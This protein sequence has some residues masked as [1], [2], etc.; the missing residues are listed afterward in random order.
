MKNLSYLLLFLFIFTAC[1][2][3]QVEEY[4]ISLSEDKIIADYAGITQT[5][6]VQSNDDNW[7]ILSSSIPEWCNIEKEK[8]S[9]YNVEITISPNHTFHSREALITFIYED[10]SC[11]LHIFQDGIQNKPSLDWHTFPVNSFSNVEIDSEVGLSE[12]NYKIIASEIYINS[13]IRD[14]I[15]HG[16]LIQNKLKG[17]NKV[18]E[19]TQYSYNPIAISGFVNGQFYYRESVYPSFNNTDRLY[20]E[21]KSNNTSQNFQFSYQTSPIQY[22][23]YKHLNLL[24]IGNLG[25]KLDEIITGKSYTENELKNRTGLIYSYCNI[26]FNTTINLPHNLIKETIPENER[27]GLSYI[28]NIK[29]GK[30]AFLILETDYDYTI[31][32]LVVG[33][34]M[35]DLQLNDYEEE[36]KSS[37]NANYIFFDKDCNLNILKGIDVIRMF[38]SQISDQPIIP[39]NFSINNYDNNSI[40]NFEL[41]FKIP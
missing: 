31:S 7:T 20:N 4:L 15:F 19:Y 14:K 5:I 40:G 36:I 35:K 12:R 16:N 17:I 9:S 27:K 39:L 6:K 8:S 18:E 24:G 1:D 21:I 10:K 38:V 29:Y 13:S 2:N 23:S 22:N 33:K 32:S 41:A 30:M 34:I 11:T 3:H 25:L 37:I 26:L 28:N